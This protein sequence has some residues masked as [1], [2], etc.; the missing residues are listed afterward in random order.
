[1]VAA[2][3]LPSWREDAPSAAEVAI[4]SAL[5]NKNMGVAGT[6]LMVEQG[7]NAL[8]QSDYHDYFNKVSQ[9]QQQ[10]MALGQQEAAL[11]GFTHLVDAEGKTP[12]ALAAARGSSI[13]GGLIPQNTGDV[14]QSALAGAN[15]SNMEK[16][17]RGAGPMMMGGAQFPGGL[18]IPQARGAP[19]VN[20]PVGPTPLEKAAV[21]NA[22]S[23][24]GAAAIGAQGRDA[25]ELNMTAPGF[26]ATDPQSPK[27]KIKGETNINRFAPGVLAPAGHAPFMPASDQQ[28]I[29]ATAARTNPQVFQD[30]Q[31]GIQ[32]N[33]GKARIAI[34]PDTGRPGIVGKNGRVWSTIP[35]PQK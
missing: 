3:S 5:A 18:N 9:M 21:T 24:L 14:E 6:Q 11:T 15:A 8:A 1:M 20:I 28:A 32:L 13:F 19:P 34:D 22:N 29:L 7:R 10:N 16:F 23:R 31:A 4:Q 27:V 17:G 30:I 35:L 2:L 26:D 33:G 12:G 25:P